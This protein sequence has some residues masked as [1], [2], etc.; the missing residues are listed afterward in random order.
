MDVSV[1]DGKKR[2][3]EGD[4]SRDGTRKVQGCR[5]GDWRAIWRASI[6]GRRRG[7]VDEWPGEEREVQRRTS[8]KGEGKV[9]LWGE[10]RSSKA[11]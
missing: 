6:D 5:L 11:R 3:S 2:R 9:K 1:G 10:V 4:V 8:R 7:R